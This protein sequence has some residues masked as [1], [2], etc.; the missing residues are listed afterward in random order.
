MWSLGMAPVQINTYDVM[1]K[2]IPL[3]SLRVEGKLFYGHKIVLVTAS[4]RFQSMLSSKLSDSTTP[5]V[6]INDIR[7]HIFQLVMQ[8]LYSGGCTNL[9]VSKT[10]VLELM[11]AA[12]FFQLEG[13]LRYTESRCSEMID[14]DNVVAMYIHAKVYKSICSNWSISHT[15]HQLSS[16]LLQVYNA[17]KLLEFCQGFLLQNMVA[18]LTYDDSVKR[19]LFAK[20][21]PN[22]DVLTGLLQALQQRI[23]ERKSMGTCNFRQ[24]LSSPAV[25]TSASAAASATSNSSNK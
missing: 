2:V 13:L 3:I 19:L 4:P 17:N 20:K 8:Y 7:Y 10:D 18:L 5:T 15:P 25:S 21:I 12:S 14:I 9:D 11:A 16:P 23:K 24:Q 6:Q 1:A 22:H